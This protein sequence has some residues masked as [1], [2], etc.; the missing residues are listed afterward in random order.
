M[1]TPT[2]QTDRR[3][4]IDVRTYYTIH[5][6]IDPRRISEPHPLKDEL[7]DHIMDREEPPDYLVYT[8]PENIFGFDMQ[9]KN[10]GKSCVQ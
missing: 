10:W 3:F 7:D 4:L 2:L 1:L 8:V 6:K 5:G 9:E